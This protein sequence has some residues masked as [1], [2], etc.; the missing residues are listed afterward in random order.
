MT[1]H[2]TINYGIVT[3][4]ADG[5]ITGG[6]AGPQRR[7][8]NGYKS[9]RCWGDRFSQ[10]RITPLLRPGPALSQGEGL[11]AQNA[12]C[13]KRSGKSVNLDRGLVFDS[14]P[15]LVFD[16]GPGPACNSDSAISHSSGSNEAG[17]RLLS[18]KAGLVVLKG[19]RVCGHPL[20]P[21]LSN[22]L[23][24]YLVTRL[25]GPTRAAYLPSPS[26]ETLSE[27]PA[28]GA[29]R[30]EDRTE[31]KSLVK[32]LIPENSEPDL[33]EISH[34][35][36]IGKAGV[37]FPAFPRIPNT[38][39]N[40]KN[41]PTGYYADLETDCQVFH[42]CDTSRKISFLCPNGTIFSQS[43]LICDWWFKVDCASAPTLY[44]SSAEYYSNE[45]KKTVKV[46][47][48]LT[49]N[50]DLQQ[51]TEV[52]P[53]NY[54][55]TTAKDIPISTTTE[56]F[57]QR[58]RPDNSFTSSAHD[59]NKATM[60][61]FQGLFSEPTYNPILRTSTANTNF[62]RQHNNV[63]QSLNFQTIRTTLPS[64]TDP[65]SYRSIIPKGDHNNLN[66][67]QIA[68]ETASFTNNNNRQFIQDFNNKNYHQFPPYS[69]T[70]HVKSSKESSTQST[71]TTLFVHDITGKVP[72][73]VTNVHQELT[74]KR[75][76]LVPYTKNY[77]S[78][79]NEKDQSFTSPE[80]SLLKDYV[81]KENNK[82][83]Q[84]HEV[85]ERIKAEELQNTFEY[86]TKQPTTKKESLFTFTASS[87]RF[88]TY[89]NENVYQLSTEPTYKERRERLMR[90]LN[91]D[92]TKPTEPTIAT[93]N[94]EKY[95]DR[96][97]RPGL[98]VPPS[99]T[100]KTLHNLAIYYATGLDNMESTI[101]P[102][103]ENTTSIDQVE[104]I[105]STL[106]ALFSEHTIN[107]Y[108]SLFK[109]GADT[110]ELLEEMKF[111]P[112]ITNEIMEDLMLQQ[113]QNG[114]SSSPQIRELAQVFTHALSAYLQDPV[115][116]RKVLSD[117]RP[118]QPSFSDMIT[119]ANPNSDIS[120]ANSSA[121][122]TTA[123][124]ED[125]EEILGFSDENKERPALA[126]YRDS[127]GLKI[128]EVYSRLNDLTSATTAKIFSR[129]VTTVTPTTVTPTTTNA[130]ST[131]PRIPFRC[132][133]ARISA[134]YTTATPSKEAITTTFSPYRNTIA[135]N[136]NTLN[137]E[138][139]TET[140]TE[141]SYAVS[142]YGGFQ[143]NT[144]NF[145]IS[146]YG[147]DVQ[148]SDTKPL[149]ERDYVKATNLPT[150][151][152]DDNALKV[153]L[154][155]TTNSHVNEYDSNNFGTSSTVTIS[156]TTSP[157][158]SETESLELENEEELQRAHSQSFIAPQNNVQRQEKSLIHEK[159]AIK[160]PSEELEAPTLP[161]NNYERTTIQTTTSVPLTTN[162]DVTEIHSTA[163]EDY[164]T[165][166][167]N[168]KTTNQ[169]LWSSDFDNWHS[170]VILDPIT[171]NDGLS[172]TGDALNLAFTNSDTSWEHNSNSVGTTQTD[173]TGASNEN[174]HIY[175]PIH[176]F[177][178]TLVQTTT[179]NS[180]DA[181]DNNQRGGRQLKISLNTETPVDFTTIAGT[182][183]DKAK[184][185]MG[186]MNST[187]A[188]KLM[189][190]MRMTK[191]KTVRRLILLLVQTCDDDNSTA[192][193]SKRALLEAL[194]SVS[195]KDMDEL[196]KAET[197]GPD[198]TETTPNYDNIQFTNAHRRMDRVLEE[199]EI[200]TESS[201]KINP[202]AGKS[203]SLDTRDINS[204]SN[205][206][207]TE[208]ITPRS[209]FT[210]TETLVP[211]TTPSEFTSTTSP[212]VN[213]G[214][215]KFQ[216]SASTTE[217]TTTVASTSGPVAEARIASSDKTNSDTR[218]IELLKSLYTIAARW[219]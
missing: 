172:P 38:G 18:A 149:S 86:T 139:L 135:A 130:R 44:Q 121:E 24:F 23:S 209:T 46:T 5:P 201:L 117:I 70:A 137:T 100:P 152:G 212:N 48:R 150:A 14:D 77:G 188:E 120:I 31:G 58:F 161:D 67:M 20:G 36:V 216:I 143:N 107:K 179:S 186:G 167:G 112:N 214:S 160:K 8:T 174:R 136:V 126:G 7:I 169:F 128:P 211:N 142:K 118:T 191:S 96:P 50:P 32:R 55:R 80:V 163:S 43:H 12:R 29:A 123:T 84:N 183:V 181:T 113:S 124:N 76:T 60:R 110:Q 195:Q 11:K 178:Q 175:E 146:P 215:K 196:A 26:A 87:E 219:G 101:P 192:E 1:I 65:P 91:F 51:I 109:P 40:C 129:D 213:R 217:I 105:D 102:E 95:S 28:S 4:N 79:V 73:Q 98:I 25:D 200:A 53:Q 52:K 35:G 10:D 144:D 85:E 116:F 202:R 81:E 97:S 148:F 64:Y 208:K 54:R 92:N 203:L 69:P 198:F 207:T 108:S 218:A 170:T 173:T 190:V 141:N 189:N 19:E 145:N 61:S 93:E 94:T 83:A 106:P 162:Y 156:T 33:D 122:S 66:E 134:S 22:D 3:R 49:K 119:T 194:M 42:I 104:E 30:F 17:V 158:A 62:A 47:N 82:T 125:D 140:V 157:Y 204:L 210:V 155:P 6:A 99:L 2:I 185:I 34:Q 206:T 71:L 153:S 72:N 171:V 182:V 197:A 184:E 63:V 90:K 111:D 68:A 89:S 37:D 39:F 147:K 16:P 13:K 180:L 165:S 159:E 131:T 132:C 41:V 168:D 151:W 15:T 114:L 88:D 78:I 74:T 177:S 176:S 45:Q 56:K 133:A 59:P 57:L 127:K 138:K 115:Q 199:T 9:D 154:L 27:L 193:A 103:V 187:T 75:P 166:P 164:F 21:F 205:P